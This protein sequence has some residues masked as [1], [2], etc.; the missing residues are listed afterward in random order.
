MPPPEDETGAAGVAEAPV[1]PVPPTSL[2]L[3]V[4][5]GAVP[6]PGFDTTV[7]LPFCGCSQMP[8]VAG[9]LGGRRRS[10]FLSGTCF[11]ASSAVMRT[12]SSAASSLSS[13]NEE[14]GD[15]EGGDWGEGGEG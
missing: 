14:G 3:A 8:S 9:T 7:V 12:S 15:L 2:R 6:G 13:D 1:L 11:A 10:R 5:P 4:A